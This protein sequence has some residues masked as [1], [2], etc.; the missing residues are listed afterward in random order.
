LK[1]PIFILG[2]ASGVIA[3][4]LVLTRLW[5]PD[6]R[7][8]A[9]HAAMGFPLMVAPLPS[10]TTFPPAVTPTP[11]VPSEPIEAAS[12]MPSP[13]TALSSPLPSETATPAAPLLPAPS[14]PQAELKPADPPVLQSDIDRLRARALLIPVQGVDRKS[15]RD[16]FADARGSQK[17]QA[18]DIMAARGTPVLA[19]GDGRVEKLFTSKP[20]GLTIYEFDPKGE[21]CYYYAHLDGY[22]PGLEAGKTVLKGEVIGYVGSTGNA[23]ATAPHLHFQIFRLGPDKRW[24]EGTAIDAYPLWAPSTT[25]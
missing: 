25:P 11:V 20:G 12:P 13:A 8:E 19:A 17:H 24:W 15:L 4:Y 9:A 23:S 6:I 2:F 10:P 14:P 7:L 16:T 3:A 21:Y 18:I 22:A 5:W 1:L